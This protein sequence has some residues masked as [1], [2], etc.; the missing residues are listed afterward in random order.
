MAKE[1]KD[2]ICLSHPLRRKRSPTTTTV[3]HMAVNTTES[4][5]PPVLL[6]TPT[7]WLVAAVA[8]FDTNGPLI[9]SFTCPDWFL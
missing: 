4:Q 7:A 3:V 1:G 8:S 9:N 5:A 2:L 6:A